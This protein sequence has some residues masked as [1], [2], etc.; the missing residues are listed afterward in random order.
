MNHGRMKFFAISLPLWISLSLPA[1]ADE[2]QMGGSDGG[3]TATEQWLAI[4]R[5]GR[6]AGK[7]LPI[8]GAEAGPSF[9]RYID[10][11]AHPVAEQPRSQTPVTT[12]QK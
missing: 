4:Q 1:T 6:V 8:L 7:L 9:R 12:G 11:F 3:R 5:E 10:S 2:A